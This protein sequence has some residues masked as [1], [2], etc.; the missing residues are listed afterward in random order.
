MS[1]FDDF[2]SVYPK[3]KGSNPKHPASLKFATAVK[4]GADPAHIVSSARRY[5]EELEEQHKVGTEYVCMATTW[6]NQKRWIDYA[7][8]A[9]EE[10]TERD[11]RLDIFMTEKG[12]LWNGQRWEKLETKKPP[13]EGGGHSL[14]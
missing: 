3:R 13:P 7:P 14:V 11:K 5:A 1:T 10:R 6:L 9:I 12:Y 2:W 8:V 4:N